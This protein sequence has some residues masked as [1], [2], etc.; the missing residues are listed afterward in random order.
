MSKINILYPEKEIKAS[1]I[2]IG[3]YFTGKVGCETGLFV[4][5]F[6]GIIKIDD[7]N[8]TWSFDAEYDVFAPFVKNYHPVDIEIKIMPRKN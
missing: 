4:R 1:K 7:P 5:S 6:L 8:C 2:S 3:T